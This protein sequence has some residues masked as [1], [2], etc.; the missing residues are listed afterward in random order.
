[1]KYI[2]EQYD[3][4]KKSFKDFNINVIF[5]V[6]F[7]LLFYSLSILTLFLY[8]KFIQSKTIE[9]SKLPIEEL[10]TLPE[11]ELKFI[12]G[13]LRNFLFILV[14]GAI[15]TI[16]II[17]MITCIFKSLI[18][19][20]IKN[21]KLTKEYFK[22][23]ILIKILWNIIW[24]IPIILALLLKQA[25]IAPLLVLIVIAGFHFTNIFYIKFKDLSSIKETFRTGI[26]IHLFLLPYTFLALLFLLTLQ[27]YWIYRFLPDSIEGVI[28][29]MIILAYLVFARTYLYNNVKKL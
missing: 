15:I 17:F 25:L 2:Q 6:L 7:D 12:L 24:L 29:T 27:L 5:I 18:W 20:K 23:F 1:M 8:S 22:K 9:I 21:K 16:A 11:E 4:L 10:M 13:D 3:I 14:I 19:L 28:S 26:R